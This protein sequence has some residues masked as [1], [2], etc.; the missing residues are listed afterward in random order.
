MLTWLRRLFLGD[1]RLFLHGSHLASVIRDDRFHSVPDVG[2]IVDGPNTCILV[3]DYE[4]DGYIKIHSRKEKHND[5]SSSSAN[6]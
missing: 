5:A 3:L 6:L 2:E 1:E 4:R